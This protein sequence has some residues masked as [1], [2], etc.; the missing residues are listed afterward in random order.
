MNTTPWKCLKNKKNENMG[1]GCNSGAKKIAPIKRQTT[2]TSSTTR[3]STVRSTTTGNGRRI[4][5]KRAY[6]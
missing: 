5:R 3:T 4:I 6:N 2:N 1:C